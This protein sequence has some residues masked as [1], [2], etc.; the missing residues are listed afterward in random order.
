MRSRLHRYPLIS[1]VYLT[2][3]L[4]APAAVD[5]GGTIKIDDTKSITIG[6]GLRTSFNSVEDG[7][8]NGT[9]R[10]KNFELDSIRLYVNGKIT[11]DIKLTFNTERQSDGTNRVLDGI[12]QFAFSDIFNVWAGRFLPP[13]D[14][15]NLS[16]PY[17]LATWDFPLV[18]AYPAIFAGRD[19]GLAVWGQ[20][21]G[22]K[23]KYQ[24]G[25]FQGRNGAATSNQSDSLL[26][27]GR[28][29]FNLWDPEPGYYN[30]STYYGSKEVLAF[31]LAG[32]MQSDGAGTA[33][34]PGDFSGWSIDAL[35]EK[36]LG[37]DVLSLEGAHYSYDTGGVTD[38]TLIDGR[39][40]FVLAG[41]LL[42]QKF[43]AGKLQP[44]V[45]FQSLDVTGASQT[46]KRYDLGL[47]YI[48]DGHNARMSFIY[49]KDNN[50]AAKDTNIV[51]VGMQ[52]QI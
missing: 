47:N 17:Y 16:G 6:A 8:P 48:F 18:Q 45:R 11:R 21:G 38:A 19:D 26:Y 50:G 33:A 32:Q 29:T 31:G 37:S 36:K 39:G 9:D 23:Y 42:G 35:M 7:A 44:H 34:T 22:G 3:G 30:D 25:A 24:V 20:T 5:A 14:R 1:A 49:A 40:Y 2:C 28:L 52:L 4:M 15:S 13:S 27:A 10:S 43:G 41:Y 46:R 12:A 51:R